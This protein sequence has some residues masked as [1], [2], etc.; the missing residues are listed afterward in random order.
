METVHCPACAGELH[1]SEATCPSCG[2]WQGRPTAP[3]ERNPF[4]LIALCVLWAVLFWFVSLF[5]AEAAAGAVDREHAGALGA[6]LERV[7]GGPFLLA[8]IGL[9]IVLT[10]RGKLPGTA[11]PVQP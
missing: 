7:L 2:A 6:W 11:K 10:V 9:S 4:K 3:P 5:L 8:S 1:Q